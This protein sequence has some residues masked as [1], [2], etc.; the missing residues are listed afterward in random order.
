M[1]DNLAGIGDARL[2]SYPGGKNG[3]GVYQR[4][5]NLMPPH[6]VYIEAFLG[7]AAVMR[8]KRPAAVNIGIDVDPRAVEMARLASVG[9]HAR[10][11]DP[12][13]DLAS[14]SVGR[15][16]GASGLA[17]G[18]A[19]RRSTLGENGG[20]R[21]SASFH[22]IC[23]DAISF[24]ETYPFEGRE[25]VYCDPPY[26]MSTR[27]GRKLYGEHEMSDVDHRRFLRCAIAISQKCRVMISGYSSVLYARE[28]RGWNATSFP[29]MTRGGTERA[30]WLWFNF[31]P[32]VELHDYRYLG[33]NWRERERIKRKKKRWTAKLER[34]PLLERH[35]LLAA[36]AETAGFGEVG[37]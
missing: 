32:P 18:S 12:A 22:F 13:G 5:I 20:A 11:G 29:S 1:L 27:T 3:S 26:L 7:G 4:I 14:F 6:E 19:A 17:R 2:M 16:R 8:L 37:R 24:L 30:E 28:L 15:R 35:C 9:P 34:M 10:S 36:I 23:G 25:L 31:A 21:G 33:E